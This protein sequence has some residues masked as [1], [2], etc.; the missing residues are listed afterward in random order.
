M[1]FDLSLYPK[2]A[3]L[4]E[5]QKF[6]EIRGR[7]AGRDNALVNTLEAFSAVAETLD[8][9]KKQ[10]FYGKGYVEETG[11]VTALPAISDDAIRVL[12]AIIGIA[13]EAGELVDAFLKYVRGEMSWEAFCTN[14]MEE[15]GDIEWYQAL[16]RDVTGIIEAIEKNANNNKLL[17]KRYG[18]QFDK[19][20]AANRNLDEEL[21]ALADP[22]KIREDQP[23]I[24]RV[25]DKFMDEFNGVEFQCVFA[26]DCYA[27]L[28]SDDSVVPVILH[29][30]AN[31]VPAYTK[32]EYVNPMCV[33]NG[34]PNG[35]EITPRFSQLT[36]SMI[37]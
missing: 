18:L 23:I 30:S 2:L 33:V 29:S 6:D 7:I 19:D 28:V 5:S 20:K 31:F 24:V 21:K 15:G 3:V 37:G 14:M 1:Q 25:N 17:V 9:N 26:N 4:T 34:G 36:R 12:H 8:V 11:S 27:V 10:I 35:K 32:N 13:T 16:L 22:F